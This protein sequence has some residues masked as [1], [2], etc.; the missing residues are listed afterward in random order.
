MNIGFSCGWLENYWGTDWFH[1]TQI[2]GSEHLAVEVAAAM[3][4]QGHTVT[5]RLPYETAKDTAYRGVQWISQASG[6]RR[7]DLLFCFDDFQRRDNADRAVLVACRSDPPP[8]K[9]FDQ[10]I[11]LSSI[12]R[13]SWVIRTVRRSEEE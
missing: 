4:A 2:G 9:D 10:M 13:V 8:S 3:A 11:F 12:T 6:S 1:A 7:Y 5:V